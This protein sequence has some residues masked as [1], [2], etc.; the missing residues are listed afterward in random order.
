M[1]L[2][3]LLLSLLLA[4][5]LIFTF[6]IS[7]VFA[8]TADTL[9]IHYHRYDNE[10]S[11]WDLWLWPEGNEGSDYAF[12][13]SDSYGTKATID[14][15]STSLNG[16]DSIGILIKDGSWAKDYEADRFIDM[17]NPNGSGEVHVYFLQGEGYMSYVETDQVGCDPDNP[18]PNLCAQV[19]A[20]GL[21]DVYFDSSYDVN[22][23][24]TDSI[25]ASDITIYKDGVE[26]GFTG[27]SSGTTGSL[28]LNDSVDLTKTYTIEV[29][30][31][32]E[33]VESVI[34]LN[35]DYDSQAFNQAYNYNGTLGHIYGE[36]E[37]TFK[38]WAP[39]S[40]KVEVNLY[41]AGHPI[42]VRSDGADVAYS[43]IEMEYLEKGVWQTT[44]PG[45]LHGV[46]YTFNV[47]N[48]GTKVYD[49]QDPYGVT[50]GLNGQRAMV[51]DM[52]ETN[53]VG[54]DT[55]EGINGYEN[56]NDAIIYELHVRDLTSQDSWG[57]PS[58]YQGLYMGLTVAE[59]SYTHPSSGVTV[60]TGLDHLIELGITHLH[61]L[62]TYD[63][64]WNDERNFQFNWGYN[65][66]NYNSPEGG[67]ST[68]P[69]DGAVR[70]NE[71]KQMVMALHDNG[72]NVINDVVYNHTGPGS[73]YSFNR[74]VP[75]YFYRL[76]N[77]GSYS[78]GSGVGNET[79]S[80]RYMVNKFIV[81]SVEYWAE[82]FHIDGFRFDLMAIHDYNTMNDVANT[83][84][85]IDPD[86]FVYGEPWGGGTIALDWNQQAGKHNLVNMPLV[87]AFN[88]NFRN[89]IKGSPDG[90]DAG[91]VTNGQGIYDIM[92][93]IEG[94]GNWNYG[95]STSQSIN[96]VTAHDNKTLYDK[97]ISVHGYS[98]YGYYEELDY[99]QRLANSIVLLSQGVPFLHAGVDFLRTKG[100]N[101]N[102]YDASDQVNQLN[103]VRKANYVDSFEYYKGIIEIRK[104]FESFRMSD[105][106]DIANNLTFLYPDGY[107]LIG[108]QL[109]KNNENILVY[110][111][112]GAYAN[113]ITLPSGAWKLIAD[114]D[115][116]GLDSLGT[117]QTRY[118]IEEAET[119][120]FVEGNI[121][122][123]TESPS[124][125]PEITNN[126]AVVYE[127]ASF[128]V[129]ST[130][131]IAA[132]SVD[133]GDF[134]EVDTPALYAYI[135]NLSVG[136]HQIRIKDSFGG[137]SDPFTVTV[138]AKA[139]ETCEENPDQDKCEPEPLV[140]ETGYEEV[141]G[142]CVLIE[143]PL[144]CDDGYEEVEGECVL[145]EPEPEPKTGC[146][147]S[148]TI[149]RSI[150]GLV[151]AS[152]A[153]VL[154]FFRR[155]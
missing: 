41:T 43:V 97:L 35:V 39:V 92:S 53:P 33:T 138:L 27:F 100:G 96:Y 87:A 24:S 51:V 12:N 48:S 124:H 3:K 64:D 143:E 86:I 2:R 45:D 101:H 107:G 77:D 13:G 57:G 36:T 10:Y 133:G 73:Y 147:S 117:Y 52:E 135:P 109:T 17:T 94:S 93:G 90:D 29:T 37:T 61:L 106:S 98:S 112:G 125:K 78:N 146:F 118:P 83:V 144:V 68:D 154:F 16:A 145:I 22:F 148:I 108:Y 132:Y 130:S 99:E 60:S 74:I 89:A 62:P 59:T 113:D 32:T 152:I 140:C 47:V 58:E 116:A 102:S 67:Y 120:I 129:N 131:T 71:Y 25:S 34:R 104:A 85:A 40:S 110:H 19:M 1:K 141:D 18:D 20:S 95:S 26:V 28:Q 137:I 54:W 15:S 5:T 153:G 38:L 134:V 91:F 55:D 56:V 142:E 31:G 103:W 80:E 14:L 72:I 66:Q 82:E 151:M 81:D 105:R 69:Y 42:S 111:N 114:R 79:A 44:V 9:V 149:G 30:Y 126:L 49:I 136:S 23:I 6:D 70:I 127:G 11:D 21:L 150:I 63:Q 4:I 122:D 123:V 121:S 8:S 46:Y 84:E 88:D 115:E 76:N 75:N 119:L 65:P 155:K 7:G 139:E 128:R 50:F